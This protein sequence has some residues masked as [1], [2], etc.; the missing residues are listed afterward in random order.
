MANKPTP[1]MTARAIWPRRMRERQADEAA[2]GV[3]IG[4]RRAFAGQIRQEEQA[5]RCP[6]GPAAAS[7]G[8]DVV[9]ARFLALRDQVLAQTCSANHCS[10]PPADKAD[11][12]HVPLAVDRVAERVQPAERIDLHSSLWTNMTPLVPIEVE[13][14]PRSTMPVPTAF[15]AQSPAP[16]TTTQS[17][18]RPSSFGRLR[19]QLAGDFFRFIALGRTAT[20]I[21][22]ELRQQ[23]LA[24]SSAWPRRAAA[25]RWRR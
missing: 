18:V 8:E 19:R 3:G 16:P 1:S 22:F 7:F 2:A 20:G 13:S 24:T 25:C 9:D 14:T 11:A 17:V 21:E 12:H 10:E 15:A 4:V 23:L 6:R 5:L